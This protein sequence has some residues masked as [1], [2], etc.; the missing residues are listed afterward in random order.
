M[1]FDYHMEMRKKITVILLLSGMVLALLPLSANRSFIVRPGRLLTD[2]LNP[3]VSL[4]ADQVAKL[5]VN[6][7]STIRLIDLRP[8]EEFRKLNIPGSVNIPYNDFI[9]SDLYIY[10]NDKKAKNIFYSNSDFY[11][12]YAMVYARGLGYKNSY[13]MEGGLNE[14]FNTVM[15]SEFTGERI[16]ARENALFETRKKAA[17]LFTQ[18]NSMPDSLKATFMT[19]N[20]FSARK[21]DGGCE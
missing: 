16:S 1:K 3:E 13:V 10:M 20:K 2:I 14:W 5:I 19:S 18:I 11:S 7:D 6:D 12:N 15:E 21:L 9:S 17:R 4:T 8:T